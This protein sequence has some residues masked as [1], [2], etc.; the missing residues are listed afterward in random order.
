MDKIILFD[1]MLLIDNTVRNSLIIINQLRQMT[2]LAKTIDQ[3]KT[4][5]N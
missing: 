5:P 1:K 2:I 3:S 4:A